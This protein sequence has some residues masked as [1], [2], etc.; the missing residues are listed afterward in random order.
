MNTMLLNPMD[1]GVSRRVGL[2]IVML[3]ALLHGRIAT[4]QSANPKI[5]VAGVKASELMLKQYPAPPPPA[6]NGPVTGEAALIG[7]WD[8]NLT[9]GSRDHLDI[10]ISRAANGSLR[11]ELHFTSKRTDAETSVVEL[12]GSNLKVAF[13]SRVCQGEVNLE[14]GKWQAMYVY[15]NNGTWRYPITLTRLGAA[16]PGGSPPPNSLERILHTMDVQLA[17][18][19]DKTRLFA[20]AASADL[21]TVVPTGDLRSESSLRQLKAAGMQYLLL[22]SLQELQDQAL[23]LGKGQ[24]TSKESSI[25]LNA[26]SA[27]QKT[28]G[29]SQSKSSVVGVAKSQKT[30]GAEQI[31]RQQIVRVTVQFDLYDTATG[32]KL[33][34]SLQK[35]LTTRPYTALASGNNVLSQTDLFETAAHDVSE[36]AAVMVSGAVFPITVLDKSEKQVTLN[37]GSE[38]GLK[39]GQ[40]YGVYTQGKELKD[41]SGRV[42]GTDV[43]YVGKVIIRELRPQFS[44]ADILEDKAIAS[45]HRLRLQVK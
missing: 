30:V 34:S 42:L 28:P 14:T 15:S 7:V 4:A 44:K 5:A 13:P 43:D 31:K 8:G 25:S 18:R 16:V 20:V 45:G 27:T 40:L 37:R 33:E 12:R 10:T 35:F 19:L 21:R 23:D 29:T 17:D 26:N 39:V 11:A 3:A 1:R 32:N 2:C 22:T 24:T 36:R 6:T 41:A 9:G 38:A